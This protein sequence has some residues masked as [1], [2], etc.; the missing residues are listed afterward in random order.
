MNKSNNT[1][2]F[3]ETAGQALEASQ[4]LENT[5]Q[6]ILYFLSILEFIDFDVNHASNLLKGIESATLGK[7]IKILRTHKC[8]TK[9]QTDILYSALRARNFLIHRFFLDTMWYMR[10]NNWNKTDDQIFDL[11]T[12]IQNGTQTMEKVLNKLHKL[13]GIDPDVIHD[14]IKKFLI[15]EELFDEEQI[16]KYLDQ[17]GDD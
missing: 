10:K 14:K 11:W 7:L 16:D 1:P 13:S 9:N 17:S 3:Y 4:N 8:L 6:Q 15:E 12:K 2:K 5:L